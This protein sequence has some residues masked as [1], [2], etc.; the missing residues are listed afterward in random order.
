MRRYLVQP[1]LCL[2]LLTLVACADGNARRRYEASLDQYRA[3]LQTTGN[4]DRQRRLVSIDERA[5]STQLG[6]G[7]HV[8]SS[9]D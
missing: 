9:E 6:R 3:C 7:Y 4:C 2:S 1:L 5:Y 8:T